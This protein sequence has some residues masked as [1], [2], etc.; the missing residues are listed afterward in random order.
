[1]RRDVGTGIVTF[2]DSGTFR[3]NTY[4]GGIRWFPVA[5][6]M[7]YLKYAKATSRGCRRP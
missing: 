6:H 1:M 3:E 4:E 5:G 2:T 7:L